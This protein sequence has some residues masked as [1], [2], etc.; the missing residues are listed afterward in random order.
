MINEGVNTILNRKL[1]CS[2]KLKKLN[3]VIAEAELK[4]LGDGY[5]EGMKSGY[6]M[7]LDDAIAEIV[8]TRNHWQKRLEPSKNSEKKGLNDDSLV[9]FE[10]TK[11]VLE[12]LMCRF[13][14]AKTNRG[15]NLGE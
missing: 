2:Q 10:F 1:S 9:Y 6:E 4:A 7:G 8:K 14:E 12:M 13:Q 11:M 3:L 15:I 5:L